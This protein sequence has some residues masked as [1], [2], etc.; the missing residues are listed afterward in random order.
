MNILVYLIVFFFFIVL[1]VVGVYNGADVT[2]NL[3]FWQVGP[4]PMG[5]V[6]AAAAIF[7]VAFACTIGVIDG[8]KIRITNRLLRKQ[9][10]RLEEEADSL[11][12]RLARREGADS[13]PSAA[14][15]PTASWAE[16]RA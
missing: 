10:R 15:G 12:L 16:P 6:V 13:S 8:I 5:A 1:F 7:G 11:R 9:M 4:V 2:V 3:V 14:E